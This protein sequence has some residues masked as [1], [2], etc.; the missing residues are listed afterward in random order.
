[1]TS[2]QAWLSKKYLVYKFLTN[3]WFVGAVWLYFYRIFIT[4]Q[5]VGVLDGMAFAI[6]L[7]AEVPSGALA[8]KFGRDK[9]VRLGQILAGSGLL[10]QAAGSSFMPFFVGQAIMMIG[11]AFVSG[12]DEAL[13]FERLKFDRES[14]N[15]RKLVTRGSQVALVGT[16][17]AIVAGGVLHNINPR[18]PWL[19]TGLSFII[20]AMLVWSVK[21]ERIKDARQSFSAEF[22][23]YF[24][25]IKTGFAEFRLPKLWIYV[26][27]IL[28]VQGLFYTTGYGL[29]RLVLLD[30]FTFSP[31]LGSVAVASSSLLTILLLSYMHKNAERLSE[32]KVLTLISLSAAAGLLLSLA[33]I[34]L[35]GY[36]VIFALYAGE[37]VLQPFMSEILNYH[38]PERQRAT[39]LS[40]AS[41]LKSLPYVVLAPIIGYLNT[42][43]KLHYF[44]V[45]WAVLI[46][47]AVFIYLSKKK[48]DEKIKVASA[49]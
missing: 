15:W 3:L 46:F 27:I 33:N 42:N 18:I 29:L 6:G 23:S 21:D 38:A 24:V 40:V 9:M 43:G 16:L 49:V 17:I 34:G 5:Q 4:D 48:A 20:S 37:H 32:K 1:M 41:F 31:F 30:R 26:P 44:L 28:T 25:D 35:W 8:D 36:I 45:G 12:A 13:F 39:V 19:L 14:I 10:I 7:I 47:V 22:K 11:V 2:E